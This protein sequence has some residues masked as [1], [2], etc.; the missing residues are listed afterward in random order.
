MG[1]Q[2]NIK[3]EEAYRLATR[4]AELTGQSL[5][6]AVTDALRQRVHAEEKAREKEAMVRDILAIAG[7]IRAELEKAGGEPASSNHD[8]LYDDA[9]GLPV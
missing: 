1:M 9:T 2:L 6:G 5:T 3:S 4:L 8:W 7:E